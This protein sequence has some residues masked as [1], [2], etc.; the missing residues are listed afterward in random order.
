MVSTLARHESGPEAHHPTRLRG[1]LPT[2]VL[3][4]WG[5]VKLTDVTHEQVAAWIARLRS[6]GLSASTVR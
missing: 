1:M 5:D 6:T 2:H 4:G 3:P